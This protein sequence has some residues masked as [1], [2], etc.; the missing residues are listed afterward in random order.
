MAQTWTQ[1]IAEGIA[2]TGV[3]GAETALRLNSTFS[4]LMGPV[5]T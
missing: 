2:C 4:T 3:M 5:N 1:S